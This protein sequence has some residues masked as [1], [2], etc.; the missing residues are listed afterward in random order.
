MES[1]ELSQNETAESDSTAFL[2]KSLR[3]LYVYAQIFGC[4]SFSYTPETGVQVK[5]INIFSLV[6]FTVFFTAIAYSNIIFELTIDA[7]GYQAIL[8]YFGL[9]T[10]LCYTLLLLWALTC[11]IFLAKKRIAHLMEEIIALDGEVCEID[12]H[13]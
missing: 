7:K 1:H 2:Y 8:F 6:F 9:R 12:N 13:K 5:A 4:A 11:L 3:R 10:M